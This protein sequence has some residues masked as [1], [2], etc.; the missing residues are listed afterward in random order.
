LMLLA[1]PE[2]VS[3][4]ECVEIVKLGL[5]W[6]ELVGSP[7]VLVF[8]V[9][10]CHAGSKQILQ[11]VSEVAGVGCAHAVSRGLLPRP[12]NPPPN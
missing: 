10:E 1:L 8:A 9:E 5:D 7:Y 12:W 6:V 2:M 4:V 3:L 11:V